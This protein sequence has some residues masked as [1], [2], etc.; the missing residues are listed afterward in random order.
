VTAD[1]RLEPPEAGP[2]A[3]PPPRGWLLTAR[4]L[5]DMIGGVSAAWVR[6]HVPHKVVLGHSTVRWYE[7]DVREWLERCRQPAS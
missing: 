3:P 6:R 7:R 1:L 5:A 2:L 4:E